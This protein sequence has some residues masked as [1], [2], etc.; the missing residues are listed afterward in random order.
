MTQ[1]PIHKVGIIALLGNCV[2]L[3]QPKGKATGT[4]PFVLPRGTRA[5]FD[6]AAWVDA[7]TAEQAAQYAAALEA[8]EATLKREAW[9]EAGISAALFEACAWRELGVRDYASESKGTYPILWYVM[10]LNKAQAA[11]LQPPQDSVATRFVTLEE[12]AAL[13]Q[14]KMA[15]EGYLDVVREAMRLPLPTRHSSGSWNPSS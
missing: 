15:R 1:H 13:V 6:G 5:Y 3:V 10:W 14:Q 4:P 7:R 9:E 8:P 11:M 12:C 2:L